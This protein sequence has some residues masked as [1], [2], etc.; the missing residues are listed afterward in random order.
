MAGVTVRG[1]FF[2]LDCERINLACYASDDHELSEAELMPLLESFSRGKF[3]RVKQ[4]DLVI[5]S[6]CDMMAAQSNTCDSVGK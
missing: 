6:T 3:T 2:A 4:L 1:E 5:A